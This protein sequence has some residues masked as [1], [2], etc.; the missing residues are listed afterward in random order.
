[1]GITKACIMLGHNCH[2]VDKRLHRV[3]RHLLGIWVEIARIRHLVN[4][5]VEIKEK[6]D[7]CCE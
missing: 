7:H 2:V 6:H 1:M 3:A 5:A 4:L